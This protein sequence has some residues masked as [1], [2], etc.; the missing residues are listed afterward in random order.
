[1]GSGALL[2]GGAAAFGGWLGTV[3]ESA[4]DGFGPAGGGGN[5]GPR[6]VG[7]REGMGRMRL[8]DWT[9]DGAASIGDCRVGGDGS[10]Y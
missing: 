2:L 1:M 4:V 7:L 9:G 10:A 3:G 6:Y 8:E 5:G